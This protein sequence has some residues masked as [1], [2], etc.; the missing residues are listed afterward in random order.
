[1]RIKLLLAG[2]AA[3]SL[4][5]AGLA[6]QRLRRRPE[7]SAEPF[8]AH[9]AFLADDL[10]EG[11][12]AG[13][14]GY[15]IAA[16]YVAAQFEALGLQPGH[17]RRRLVSAGRV[18][19]LRASA[20]RR[21]LTVGGRVFTQGER[22]AVRPSPDAGRCSSRGAAGLRRLRARHA[23]RAALT[24]IAGSTCAAR[25]SSCCSGTPPGT[26]S[27]VAAH[28]QLREKARMAAARGAIGL[29]AIRTRADS[30]RD[31][32]ARAL[33]AVEPARHDL[34]RRATGS[35]YSDAP[36]CASHATVD[37]RRPTR[38]VRGRAANA[39]PACSTRRRGGGGG[40]AASRCRDAAGS[41]A[42][43][44]YDA[45]SPART[46]SASCRAPIRR[47]PANMCC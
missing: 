12:E 23:G 38:P 21:R 31:A 41:S 5:A 43:A 35:P 22:D 42:A 24:I 44:R 40:R 20:A 28:L 25:S 37:G 2:L 26:P 47:S 46:S 1:M 9:V 14:R 3:L 18:R 7:F 29:I 45:A 30:A 6:Q 33:R 27:D 15:D 4:A 11:R 36:A 32:L 17:A 10:L 16:R 13:S 8:R 39:R 19:P 34:G